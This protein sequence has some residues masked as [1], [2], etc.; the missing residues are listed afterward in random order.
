[1]NIQYSQKVIWDASLI[2]VGTI[3]SEQSVPSAMRGLVISAIKITTG[4]PTATAGKFL[5]SAHIHNAIDG[6]TYQNTGS[7]AV[8]VF[9]LI[10]TSSGGLPALLNGKIWVGNGSNIATGVTP[11]G[12]ATIANTGVITVTGAS[13]TFAA[14]GN[15]EATSAIV[16]PGGV[17]AALFYPTG[18]NPQALSGPGAASITVYQTQF[19]STGAGNA[20][21]LADA[22]QIGHVKKL[23]YVA[24]SAGGD[25]GVITPASVVGFST[26][27]LNAI[28]DYV[29]L[30]WAGAGWVILEYYGATVA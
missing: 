1:M 4:A 11:S 28:G 8:P 7:T 25:T 23:S 20:I 17:R 13:G 26:V 18:S 14:I 10:D 15:I 19:T 30:V 24:E 6:T 3:G 16:A 22:T 21:T 12:D 5:P 2:D 29:V 27:T 9:S